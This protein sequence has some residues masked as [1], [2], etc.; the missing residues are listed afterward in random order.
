MT[1]FYN[2]L[3]DNSIYIVLLIV[4][5]IWVGIFIFTNSIDKRLKSF[6]KILEEDNTNE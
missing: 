6:D 3:S 2:F 1:D 5:S 4:L